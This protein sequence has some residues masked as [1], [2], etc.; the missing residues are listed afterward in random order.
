MPGFSNASDPGQTGLLSL[1]FH[2]NFAGDTT[3]PGNGVFYTISTSKPPGRATLLG[4]GSGV[5]HDNIVHESR[6]ADLKAATASI[7]A[8]R[9]VLR[10]A[11]PLCDHGPGTIV[12]DTTAAPGSTDYGKL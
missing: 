9:E 2:P 12:F 6:V 5:D 11:Q 10:V 3:W 4:N 8:Q 1:A 7:T